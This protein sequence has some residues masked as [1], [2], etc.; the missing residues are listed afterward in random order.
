MSENQLS[1]D[2]PHAVPHP[3]AQMRK[4]DI[5]RAEILDATLEFLWSHPFREM[6]VGTLMASTTHSRSAFYLYFHDMHELMETLLLDLEE[7]ILS[8]AAPWFMGTGDVVPLLEESLAGLVRIGY[9]RGPLL[10]AVADAAPTDER[11][12]RAWSEMLG[13]FDDAVTARIEADQVQGLI[14]AFDARPIAVALN[15]LDAFTLIQEFGRRPRN[16]PEPVRDAIMRIW[17]ATLYG[18][19]SQESEGPD[20]PR[21]R[22]ATESTL[23]SRAGDQSL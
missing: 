13:R 17:T 3:S 14:P 12:D 8:V 2:R 15:R 11:L 22:R 21:I 6:S 19:P 20:A 7:A 10:R 16:R 18:V 1:T 23:P 5:T 4:S 9:E